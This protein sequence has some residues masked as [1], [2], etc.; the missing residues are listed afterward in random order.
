LG[1]IRTRYSFSMSLFSDTSMRATTPSRV[2]TSSPEELMSRRPAGASPL[3]L[4][5]MSICGAAGA[6]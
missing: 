4:C 5:F 2:K 6:G 3:P 1:A